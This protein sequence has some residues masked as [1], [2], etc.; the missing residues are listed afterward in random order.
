MTECGADGCQRL[1]WPSASLSFHDC[2][3]D[4]KN[5]LFRAELV[6]FRRPSMEAW[7]EQEQRYGTPDVRTA[8][9][10]T[11]AFISC[12]WCI[13]KPKKKKKFT[14]LQDLCTNRR[15]KWPLKKPIYI[16]WLV[17]QS[18]KVFWKA[19]HL[20]AGLRHQEWKKCA[21]ESPDGR[22][23]AAAWGASVGSLAAGQR[24]CA[25]WWWP[26][27]WCWPKW[28]LA[29]P[30]L[31]YIWF[32]LAALCSGEKKRTS[33]HWQGQSWYCNNIHSRI[34][35]FSVVRTLFPHFHNKG[36]ISRKAAG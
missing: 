31:F 4:V 10:K 9:E 15:H 33:E 1:H 6:T 30:R 36:Q 19:F 5:S 14:A 18:M 25:C 20:S 22:L 26:A 3:A 34:Q 28:S 16:L 21:E 23:Q 17:M 35:G 12:T 7:G 29:F 32:A 2:A 24:R 13:A 27:G 8:A 11:S